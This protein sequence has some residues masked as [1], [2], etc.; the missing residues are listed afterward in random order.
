MRKKS[1]ETKDKMLINRF[2]RAY[3]HF[4]IQELKDKSIALISADER[5]ST[6]HFKVKIHNNT[7]SF[8][9]GYFVSWH[10]NIDMI[11]EYLR[12]SRKL[13]ENVEEM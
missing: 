5:Y 10:F 3:K 13:L 2:N 4:E 6:V 12:V 9:V 11:Q 1:K 8:V 7:L